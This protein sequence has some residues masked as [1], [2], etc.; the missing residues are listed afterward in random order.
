MKS[1]GFL[2]T[3]IMNARYGGHI[4]PSVSNRGWSR[5]YIFSPFAWGNFANSFLIISIFVQIQQTTI[6]HFASS[7]L[8]CSDWVMGWKTEESEV[9]SRRGQEIFFSVQYSIQPCSGGARVKAVGAWIWPLPVP[10]AE[11]KNAWI[12]TSTFPYVFMAWCFTIC[13]DYSGRVV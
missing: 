7:A 12:Y 2:Y 13:A 3:L 6:D 10:S 11:V 8:T 1:L 4:H 5:W 9:D